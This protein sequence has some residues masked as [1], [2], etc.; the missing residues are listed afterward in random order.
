MANAR[1]IERGDGL[2]SGDVGRLFADDGHSLSADV[3]HRSNVRRVD[4]DARKLLVGD[5]SLLANIGGSF[6]ANR[7]Q[8]EHDGGHDA[9]VVVIFPSVLQL[10]ADARRHAVGDRH[11]KVDVGRTRSAR[12]SFPSFVVGGRLHDG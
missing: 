3:E 10:L 5:G 8:V 2:E 12:L 1:E 9:H 6:S 4:T 7:R 11:P